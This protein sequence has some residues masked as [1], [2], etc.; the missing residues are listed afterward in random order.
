MKA[1]FASDGAIF[2]HALP[3]R[4]EGIDQKYASGRR[5]AGSLE[6]ILRAINSAGLADLPVESP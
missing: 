6:Y 3:I 2:G 4:R 5:A 1:Q